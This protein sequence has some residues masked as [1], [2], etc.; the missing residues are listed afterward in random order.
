LPSVTCAHSPVFSSYLVPSTQLPLYTCF[1]ALS[2]LAPSFSCH[3]PF[4]TLVLVLLCAFL[5]NLPSWAAA[6]AWPER[7]SSVHPSPTPTLIYTLTTSF[8][9]SPQFTSPVLLPNI[10]PACCRRHDDTQ[11]AVRTF[12]THSSFHFR[13]AFPHLCIAQLFQSRAIHALSCGEFAI[14]VRFFA[15]NLP[16]LTRRVCRSTPVST[17]MPVL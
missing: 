9:P 3:L 5:R 1:L 8:L 17:L 15:P 6:R 2:S 7:P 14:F 12:C 10:A 13:R 16:R 11:A 4:P